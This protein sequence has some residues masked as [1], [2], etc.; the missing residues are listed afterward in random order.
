MTT[1]NNTLQP[2]LERGWRRGFANL[3]RNENN[4]RWGRNRWI[5]SALVWLVILNG[6]GQIVGGTNRNH[7]KIL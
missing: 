3:F 4:L 7:L 1:I 5:L 6:F 2:V